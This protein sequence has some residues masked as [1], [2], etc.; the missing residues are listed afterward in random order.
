MTSLNDDKKSLEEELKNEKFDKKV[1]IVFV[2]VL[3]AVAAYF[4]FNNV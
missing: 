1:L 4:F 2:F 3:L